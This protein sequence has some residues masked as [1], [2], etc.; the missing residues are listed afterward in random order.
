MPLL[1]NKRSFVYRVISYNGSRCLIGRRLIKSVNG[2]L[3]PTAGILSLIYRPD[4]VVVDWLMIS[5]AEL[6]AT[7]LLILALAILVAIVIVS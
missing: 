7:F 2:L 1:S 6:L 4:R 5:L 3:W